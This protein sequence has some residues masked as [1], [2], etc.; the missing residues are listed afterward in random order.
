M[1]TEKQIFMWVIHYTHMNFSINQ[2]F[3]FSQVWSSLHFFI[4]MLFIFSYTSQSFNST[5]SACTHV[6]TK[7]GLIHCSDIYNIGQQTHMSHYSISQNTGT[8]K[9]WASKMIVNTHIYRLD[10]INSWVRSL[11]V[12]MHLGLTTGP[13]CPIIWYQVKRA[14]FSL[15]KFQMAAR[16]GILI[17]SGSTEKEP[18]L[19]VE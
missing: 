5:L 16:L 13:L 4:N 15:L 12:P 6:D 3:S 14:L 10:W 8:P 19:H 11:A 18:Y 9:N 2:D 17:S 7:H 1:Y